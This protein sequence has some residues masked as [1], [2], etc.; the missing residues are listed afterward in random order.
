MAAGLKREGCP[1]ALERD[2]SKSGKGKSE[3]K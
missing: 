1:E 2:A 3:G